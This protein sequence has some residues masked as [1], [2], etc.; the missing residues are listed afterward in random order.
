MTASDG[1]EP[2]PR[3]LPKRFYKD[4]AILG[5]AAPFGIA[6]DGKPIRTPLKSALAMPT[7]ELAEAVAGE[8]LAQ[9]DVIDALAMPFTRL[10]NTAI[11]RVERDRE[12]IVD[13]ILAY[14]ASDLL[15]YRAEEPEGLMARQSSVWDPIVSWAHE[16]LGARLILAA[17]IV[18]RAQPEPA[19]AAIRSYLGRQDPFT[20]TALHNM[21]ALTGSALLASAVAE[22]RLTAAQAWSA[23]HVDEDW[24]IEQWG[25]DAEAEA[26]RAARWSE[27]EAAVRFLGLLSRQETSA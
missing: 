6:L 22:G 20:L 18:H 5:D 10:S 2:R 27:F 23:A 4:V 16:A 11:D 21:T 14:A 8:W 3:P 19:L 1:E 15:C 9:Q 26:R 13:E 7:R 17:G 12:R 24:Q 25:R